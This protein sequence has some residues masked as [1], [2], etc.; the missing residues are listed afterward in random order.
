MKM[1]QKKYS[2]KLIMITVFLLTATF[3]SWGQSIDLR[4]GRYLDQGKYIP[5]DAGEFVLGVG[6]RF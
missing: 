2:F 1:F 6:L 5:S 4:A 3:P